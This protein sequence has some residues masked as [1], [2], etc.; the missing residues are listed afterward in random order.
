MATH[1]VSCQSR[2][3]FYTHDS[4]LTLKAMQE[5]CTQVKRRSVAATFV[6]LLRRHLSLLLL[7]QRSASRTHAGV[8]VRCVQLFHEQ[9]A[10]LFSTAFQ[11]AAEDVEA[12][13]IVFCSLPV[14][15]C[16]YFKHS[17]DVY[18]KLITQYIILSLHFLRNDGLLRTLHLNLRQFCKSWSV[19]NYQ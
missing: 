13:I 9:G 8:T 2:L 6:L 15:N 10:N 11:T 16:F 3:S 1:C 17:G 12:F 14:K 4:R 7:N 18:K 19:V 5:K